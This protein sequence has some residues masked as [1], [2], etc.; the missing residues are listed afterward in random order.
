MRNSPASLALRRFVAS[1]CT[2][3]SWA[4]SRSMCG[5][6]VNASVVGVNRPLTRWKSAN[7]SWISACCKV[8]LTAGC[9]MLISRA[10][11]L[12]LP[13]SM[14]ALNTSM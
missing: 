9:V 7:P 11:A 12:T 13:V 3:S 1:R 5:Y 8:R 2:S 6:S 10:A 14:I 4:K